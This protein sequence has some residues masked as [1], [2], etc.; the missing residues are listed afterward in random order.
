MTPTN[1]TPEPG[2]YSEQS[3][4]EPLPTWW[5]CTE[6]AFT[7]VLTVGATILYLYIAV[8]TGHVLM[9]VAGLAPIAISG[10]LLCNA[11]IGIIR[12][13]RGR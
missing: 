11:A 1:E 12:R 7:A 3:A 13:L 6:L 4:D 10:G 5:L 2:Y 8:P 9:A